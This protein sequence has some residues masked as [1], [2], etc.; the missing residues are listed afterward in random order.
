MQNPA[1]HMKKVAVTVFAAAFVLLP[2]AA[3]AQLPIEPTGIPPVVNPPLVDWMS[4]LILVIAL[5]TAVI[6]GLFYARY[7]PRFR[8]S[9]A[10]DP[11]F[12][13]PGIPAQTVE[14]GG[15]AARPSAPAPAQ[16][17]AVAAPAT[18]AATAPA[19]PSPVAP[20]A[21]A[22]TAPVAAPVAAPD[23]PPT[24]GTSPAPAAAEAAPAEKKSGPVE[25]DQETF[26]RVLQEQLDK[27][28]DRRVAEGRA[29]SKA[30][31]A[32]RAKAGS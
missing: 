1:Q 12:L 3:L 11:A 6:I 31:Q 22:V 30:V 17:V 32:A 23:A 16:A 28:V 15:V 27:G 24:A 9:E 7:A 25:L 4:Y 13:R 2:T 5:L 21:P 10:D 20:A 29:K 8:R 26:D 19:S 14:I 18:P